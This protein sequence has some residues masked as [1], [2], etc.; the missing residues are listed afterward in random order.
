MKNVLLL[1]KFLFLFPA[2]I[3]HLIVYCLSTKKEIIRKDVI[4]NAKYY[5]YKG[6]TMIKLIKLLQNNR[7]FR[8]LFYFRIGSYSHLFSWYLKGEQTFIICANIAEGFYVA[9]PFAT[10]IYAKSI[11]KN[12]ICHQNTTVGDK[13]DSSKK[14]CPTIGDNVTIGANS[15]V[16]GNIRIGNNVIIGAGSIVVKDIPDN[17]VVVGNPARVIRTI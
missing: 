10:I 8:T 13:N 17:S 11:G 4:V 6:V 3:P 5:H 16:I 14:E 12:F 2:I 1:I 15:C 7:Y 9:H